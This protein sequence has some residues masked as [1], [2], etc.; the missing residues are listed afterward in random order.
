[1]L[2]MTIKDGAA[3]YSLTV[4]TEAGSQRWDL[5]K[6]NRNQRDGVRELVVNAWIRERG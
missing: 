1:M 3:E 6:L 4:E 5:S 2:K